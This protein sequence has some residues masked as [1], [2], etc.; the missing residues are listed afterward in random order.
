MQ[1]ISILNKQTAYRAKEL[2]ALGEAMAPCYL[3]RA[4]FTDLLDFA[5]NRVNT[6]LFR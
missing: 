5:L 4:G 3:S 6:H 1:R 2:G